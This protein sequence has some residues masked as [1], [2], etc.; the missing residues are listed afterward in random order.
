M[1]LSDRHESERLPTIWFQLY[2]ILLTSKII[3]AKE[4]D[5][6]DDSYE[7][8]YYGHNLPMALMNS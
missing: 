4:M 6:G 1:L 7:I 8:L 2:N 5:N 3:E